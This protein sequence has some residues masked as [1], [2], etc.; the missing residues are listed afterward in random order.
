MNNAQHSF[1]DGDKYRLKT[2]IMVNSGNAAYVEIPLN[3]TAA[4]LSRN[5]EGKTSGLN[6]LKLFLLPEVNFRNCEQKFEFKSGGEVYSGIKSF[7][8][9]FPSPNSFLI[10][11]AENPVG[12]FCVVLYR[13]KEEL[14]Y[15]RIMIDMPYEAIRHLFWDIH[16]EANNGLGKP[17]EGMALSDVQQTLLHMHGEVFDDQER[18][19]TAMYTRYTPGRRETRYCIM[20]T[21]QPPSGALLK[22]IKALLQ[23]SFDIKGASG[24]NLPQAVANII[25]SEISLTKKPVNI[26]L[27]QISEDRESLRRNAQQIQAIKNHS[28]DWQALNRAYHTFHTQKI[29]AHK[30]Y[31]LLRASLEPLEEGL[32]PQLQELHGRKTSLQGQLNG[33]KDSRN[34]ANRK[35][36]EVKGGLSLLAKNLATGQ[37][38]L[39]EAEAI[40][41]QNQLICE[42]GDPQ[43]VVEYL[44]GIL[45]DEEEALRSMESK[46]S[47]TAEL[48]KRIGEKKTAQNEAAK[49]EAL[50]ADFGQ[51][52]LNHLDRH[53]ATVLNS[54][55]ADFRRLSITPMGS[56]TKAIQGF[57][58]LF[59]LDEEGHLVLGGEP[60]PNARINHY[61]EESSRKEAENLLDAVRRTIEAV[62]KRISELHRI[63]SA[64]GPLSQEM[65]GEKKTEIVELRGEI[66]LLQRLPGIQDDV[67]NR[68]VEQEALRAQQDEY[69]IELKYAEEH[70]GQLLAEQEEVTEALRTLD[71]LRHAIKTTKQELNH[72][73]RSL[74]EL[75]SS[76]RPASISAQLI[77]DP[78]ELS[79]HYQ[80]LEQSLRALT[81]A[82]QEAEH[83]FR[84]LAGAGIMDV[85]P[86]ITHKPQL[87][88]TEFQAIYEQIRSE[89]ENIDR[90][91]HDHKSQI[92]NHNHRTSIEMSMLESMGV[93][94]ENFQ[95]R[96]NETLEGIR[97]SNLSG[98]SIRIQALQAFIE[99]RKELQDYGRGTTELMSESF[100]RR[101]MD[102][103]EKYLTSA[104]GSTKL[105]LEKIITGVRFIY[106]IQGQKEDTSQSHGTNGMINAVLLSI[107]MKK[108]VPEDV[109]FTLP[110]VFDEVGSLDEKNLPELRRVVEGS[111]MVLLVANPHNNGYIVQYIGRWHDIY[112]RK[113]SE[114]F[115]VGKCQ[116]VHVIRHEALRGEVTL[117]GSTGENAAP[118]QSA[119]EAVVTAEDEA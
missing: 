64:N 87:D 42:S 7:N 59:T 3:E 94:I 91:E 67:Q 55:N 60:L 78:G 25:D 89:F 105:N 18:I 101:L 41:Q 49:L 73:V 31:W 11:E 75:E 27:K 37:K 6:A 108:L 48:Q 30:S 70:L 47:A 103:S 50:I 35:L 24:G 116:A 1:V 19:R 84:V 86:E 26:D 14:G 119:A 2:L 4:L 112:T 81:G 57:T 22:S 71:D 39:Q 74:P 15:A 80:P 102:F 115:A 38:K 110:V 9:Y 113:L 95:S 88:D 8:Y 34:I 118:E 12:D 66:A 72:A 98:V 65:L 92:A 5:N 62:D 109:V 96:I 40:I 36:S 58:E 21:V 107:L 68:L 97:I 82:V 100:H 77:T 63:I 54:L 43:E 99:L 20:P 61:D 10:L 45:R 23:L 114:G 104:R 17:P 117:P 76:A 52:F 56:Q 29:K 13:S 28:D 83:R 111:R 90:K 106:E 69:D 32:E 51:C 16:S 44:Q 85:P 53:S 46:E 33:A 93:A 79:A